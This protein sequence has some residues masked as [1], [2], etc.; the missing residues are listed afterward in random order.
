VPNPFDRFRDIAFVT[1]I[2]IGAEPFELTL[3]IFPL[4]HRVGTIPNAFVGPTH[5]ELIA[6]QDRL[7]I[8]A[9]KPASFD[10]DAGGAK[11]QAA[12]RIDRE[13]TGAA[14]ATSDFQIITCRFW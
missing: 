2:A 10:N 1:Y 13:S 9:A 5:I 4:D 6:L 11:P 12:S 8:I 14:A 7:G 3:S